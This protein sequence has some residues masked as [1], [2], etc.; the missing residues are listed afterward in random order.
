MF[1]FNCGT[2]LLDDHG[3]CNECGTA[4][5]QTTGTTRRSSQG[6]TI[7]TST[8]R[9]RFGSIGP[10]FPAVIAVGLIV[11]FLVADRAALHWYVPRD[12]SAEVSAVAGDLSSLEDRVSKTTADVSRLN[13]RLSTLADDV[14]SVGSVSPE[15]NIDSLGRDARIANA[16][17][18]NSLIANYGGTQRTDSPAGE[19]CF[20]WLMFG[21]SSAT[22]C[23]FTR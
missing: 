11:G 3:F 19:A 9:S 15:V 5:A 2:K 13:T 4:A 7:R 10:L 16:V 22:E 12:R 20:D 21:D 14:S 6:E 18:L 8:T 17:T 1:C 23:G